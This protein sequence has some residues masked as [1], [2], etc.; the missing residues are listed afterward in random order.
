ML[1]ANTRVCLFAENQPFPRDERDL[2]QRFTGK[3]HEPY[4]QALSQRLQHLPQNVVPPRRVSLCFFFFHRFIL[5][6][7]SQRAS[8]H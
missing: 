6:L 3:K 4:A 2:P 5:L 1:T 8:T 7:F